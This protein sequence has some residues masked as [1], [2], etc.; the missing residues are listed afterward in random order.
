MAMR[1]IVGEYKAKKQE[2]FYLLAF[3]LDAREKTFTAENAET[4]EGL[5]KQDSNNNRMRRD[6]VWS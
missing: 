1:N 3:G 5:I 2:A 6:N 4:A